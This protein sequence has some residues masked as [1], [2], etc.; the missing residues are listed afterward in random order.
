MIQ[1]RQTS[2]KRRFHRYYQHPGRG[3]RQVENQNSRQEKEENGKQDGAEKE[4]IEVVI[5]RVYPVSEHVALF[6]AEKVEKRGYDAKLPVV[7]ARGCDV[8]GVNVNS[9]DGEKV[10]KESDRHACPSKAG[11]SNHVYNVLEIGLKVRD[12]G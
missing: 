10:R 12:A 11:A 7:Y 6:A 8:E 2:I 5:A 3:K 9:Q 4:L 1:E